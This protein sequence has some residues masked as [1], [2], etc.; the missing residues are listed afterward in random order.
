M[1][2]IPKDVRDDRDILSMMDLMALT[3]ILPPE[4][5]YPNALFTTFDSQ[6]AF[7]DTK[8]SMEER[9]RR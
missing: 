9:S 3:D 8:S 4:I 1:A 6:F 2:I 5:C 7:G